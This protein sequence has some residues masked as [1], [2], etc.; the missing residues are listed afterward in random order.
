[1]LKTFLKTEGRVLLALEDDVVFK[2]LQALDAALTELKQ[3]HILYLGANITDM[4]FGIKE[5]QPVGVSPHLYRIRRAW[6]SH[7][8]AYTREMVEVIVRDYPAETFE[9]YDNW[10][11]EKMLPLYD[12]YL[13]NPMVA[14]QRPG[15]SD[16]WGCQTDYTGAFEWGN[17]F[18]A[19]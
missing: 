12:A 19:K 18:M 17:K 4:V 3:W 9:M 2:D 7:A 15:R 10:L 16:L 14:Y 8:I 13:V 5:N 6:T 1:M 11:S